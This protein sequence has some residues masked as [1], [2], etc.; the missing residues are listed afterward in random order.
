MIHTEMTLLTASRLADR[1]T[2][3]LDGRARKH[4]CTG[5]NC[6]VCSVRYG[7]AVGDLVDAIFEADKNLPKAA[8]V[9]S[10]GEKDCRCKNIG[11][12]GTRNHNQQTGLMFVSYSVSAVTPCQNHLQNYS[13]WEQVRPKSSA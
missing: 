13:E 2:L 9:A 11:A 5:S 8:L 6:T 12:D 1:I 4:D 3:F 7:E 10:R